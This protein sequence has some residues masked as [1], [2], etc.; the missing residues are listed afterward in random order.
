M[1][2]APVRVGLAGLGTWGPN[3]ARNFA[4]LPDAELAWLC[5]LDPERLARVGARHP[6]TR[7]TDRLEDLL[8]DPALDAVAIATPATTHAELARRTLLAGKHAFVEKPLAM[9]AHEAEQVADLAEEHGL[10]LV[11]GHLL[12]Y[13]PGIRKL[14]EI[15][16]SGELGR[17]LV[18]YGNRQNLGKIRKD[19]NVLWS[20]GAHDLSVILDLVDEDPL[21]V[22]AR[23]A[24]FLTDGV[25]DVVF[26][27]LRFPS[28]VVAHMHL[29]WLDPHKMRK[30]TVVGDRKMAVFDDMEP[31]RKV[32]VYDKGPEE[33]PDG[34]GDWLT[35]SGDVVSP[36]IPAEEPLRLEC[37]HFVS[38]VLGREDPV[39]PRANGLAVVRVLEELQASLERETV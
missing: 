2:E 35:R 19:E 32:T 37:A 23:G 24:S 27:Y 16:R 34:Y 25:E 17:L 12:L 21:E 3:L 33:P 31:D 39:P 4:D 30:L 10:A 8:E 28:G 36:D 29:S 1:T 15:V 13:H 26:C 22:S 5:D 7:T 18:V 14:K 11:P 9:T 6:G 38:V 20:L